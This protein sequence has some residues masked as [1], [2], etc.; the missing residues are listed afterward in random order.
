[1][2][3]GDLLGKPQTLRS[4]STLPIFL[5]AAYLCT[6]GNEIS[7]ENILSGAYHADQTLD[8]NGV[9][10]HWINGGPCVGKFMELRVVALDV[11]DQ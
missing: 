10:N 5:H 2:H 3:F 8:A 6:K 7:L 9:P 4:H 1:L 11:V